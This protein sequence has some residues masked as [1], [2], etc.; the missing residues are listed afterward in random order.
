M[1]ADI[2]EAAEYYFNKYKSEKDVG[3]TMAGELVWQLIVYAVADPMQRMKMAMRGHTF[4]A[5]KMW[6][7]LD[8]KKKRERQV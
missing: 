3:E 6:E 5:Q 2:R 8:R 7:E 4:H 1:P